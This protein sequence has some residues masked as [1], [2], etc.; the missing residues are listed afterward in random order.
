MG[1]SV[2]IFDGKKF[3]FGSV[4]VSLSDILIHTKNI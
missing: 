2:R 4:P 3:K 1:T